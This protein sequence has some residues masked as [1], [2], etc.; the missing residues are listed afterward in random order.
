MSYG[1]ELVKDPPAFIKY[2]NKW[3][4]RFCFGGVLI[5]LGYQLILRHMI[6]FLF[7]EAYGGVKAYVVFQGF[8]YVMLSIS[9]MIITI[10]ILRNR[11]FQLYLLGVVSF[12]LSVGLIFFHQSIQG[13]IGVEVTSFG[14]LFIGL[15]YWFIRKE[16]NYGEEF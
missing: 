13:I 15:L 3:L 16:Q 7:G 6:V 4:V 8:G 1:S 11:K 10:M 2:T 9:Y 5:L 14:L 12:V